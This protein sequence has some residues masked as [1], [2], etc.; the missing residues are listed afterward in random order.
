MIIGLDLA[1]TKHVFRYENVQDML[2][3]AMEVLLGS[4]MAFLME[5]TEYLLVSVTSSLTLS[6]SSIIKEVVTLTLAIVVTHDEL[7]LINAIGLIICLLGITL[8]VVLKAVRIHQESTSLLA[9]SKRRS[10]EEELLM[11]KVDS[12]SEENV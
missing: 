2:T 5:V 1:L 4:I 3:T 8:H 11:E 9:N 12:D 6:V 7:S 10:K